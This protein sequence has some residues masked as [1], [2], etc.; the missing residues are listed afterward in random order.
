MKYLLIVPDGMADH[1]LEK[2]DG[3]TPVEAA[4][5]PN[6][7]AICSEG[8]LGSAHTTCSSHSPGSDVATMCLL[9]YNPD[10]YYTGRAPIEAA[11]MKIE[12]GPLDAAIRCNLITADDERLI[13]YSGGA[14]PTEDGHELI[15][16]VADELGTDELVFYPGVSYRN[17]LVRRGKGDLSV[18]ANPPHDVMN[19]RLENVL[20]TG[21]DSGLLR[22]LMGRSREILERHPVNLQR[23]R[24]GKSPA[25]M[26]W[27]WGNGLK[28]ALPTFAE[29]FGRSGCVIAAV[30]LI[31]GMGELLGWDVPHVEGATGY[32]DT[33]YDAKAEAGIEALADHDFVFVHVESPDE[34]GHE[35]NIE[36]KIK[37]IESI[38]EKVIGPCIEALRQH[39]E[40]RVLVLPDHPTPIDIRTHV[41]EAIPFAMSGTGVDAGPPVTY[42]EAKAKEAEVQFEN[43]YELMEYFLDL[44]RT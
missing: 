42:S 19:Q 10:E 15:K 35:G 27:L 32:F 31:K 14:I 16:A 21:E 33:D 29:R 34:A 7:D 38:D 2:L 37:A 12:L 39:P 11:S 13:D 6:L 44:K 17:I 43:G 1:P 20:P 41:K 4:H 28:P 24:E 23:V 26:I 22:E 36:E 30:D 5:T 18:T 40:H 9:G 8:I 3:Q 25:N